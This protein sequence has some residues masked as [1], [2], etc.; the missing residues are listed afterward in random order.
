MRSGRVRA[1][2]KKKKK[3]KDKLTMDRLKEMGKRGGGG[4]KGTNGKI[5]IEDEEG[6][7]KVMCKFDLIIGPSE[8]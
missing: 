7:K 8:I 5:G 1:G 6:I 3:K 2:G 4:G